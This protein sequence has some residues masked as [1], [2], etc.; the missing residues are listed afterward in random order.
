MADGP[1]PTQ[2]QAPGLLEE[3]GHDLPISSAR[4]ADTHDTLQAVLESAPLGPGNFLVRERVSEN[5]RLC[6][7]YS[8]HE[9]RTYFGAALM[10]L[11]NVSPFLNFLEEAVEKKAFNDPLLVGLHRLARSFRGWEKGEEA[12]EKQQDSIQSLMATIWGHITAP[13]KAGQPPPF[14]F[15]PAA[16]IVYDFIH[17]LFER[18]EHGELQQGQAGGDYV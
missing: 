13:P 1:D 10:A 18:I 6:P 9:N 12:E 8:D 4:P 5:D 14:K 15:G 17:Y 7:M 2:I 11:F 3:D 16:T